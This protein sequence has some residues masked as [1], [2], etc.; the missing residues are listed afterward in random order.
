MV[1][2]NHYAD[3]DSAAAMNALRASYAAVPDLAL[4]ELAGLLPSP[5]IDLAAEARWRGGGPTE[6]ADIPP[7]L[8]LIM[9]GR[10]ST[11][12]PL[13][14]PAVAQGFDPS[15]RSVYSLLLYPNGPLPAAPGA[16][17]PP[18]PPP[19]TRAPSR[20]SIPALEID[21]PRDLSKA[22]RPLLLSGAGVGGAAALLWVGAGVG[23][24]SFSSTRAD[25]AGGEPL[26]DAALARTVRFTNG[27][28]YAAQISTGLALTLSGVGLAFKL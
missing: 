12:R 9:D 15:G 17:R 2:L 11:R 23:A 13:T 1:A 22:S 5:L 28:G 10:P 26:D 20:R 21:A 7:D 6:P 24:L 8:T 4:E 3:R 16:E 14:R 27:L 19:V 18:P 25:V